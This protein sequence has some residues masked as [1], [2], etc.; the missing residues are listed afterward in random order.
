MEIEKGSTTWKGKSMKPN[1]GAPR[2]QQLLKCFTHLPQQ[3]LS[4]NNIENVTEYVLH[5]LCDEG[6]LNLSKAAYFI[7]N[8]DFDFIKGVAGFNKEEE[9]YTCDIALNDQSSFKEHVASCAFNKKVRDITA[10]SGRRANQ[11]PEKTVEFL[12]LKLG[13]DNPLYHTWVIRHD[14]HGLLIFERESAEETE[15]EEFVKGLSLLGF[16]PVN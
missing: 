11:S 6:C 1:G 5:S 13:F 16:C 10:P 8:P 15:Y 3:I 2:Y 7:D 12:S 9:I 4:L 14:N